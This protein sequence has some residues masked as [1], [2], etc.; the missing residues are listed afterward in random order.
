MQGISDGAARKA[1][2]YEAKK[3]QQRWY[4]KDKTRSTQREFMRAIAE[5]STPVE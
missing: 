1:A 5:V 4:A 2:S 3:A